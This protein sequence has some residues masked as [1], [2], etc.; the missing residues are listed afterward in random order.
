MCTGI[1]CIHCVSCWNYAWLVYE[2][3]FIL[4]NPLQ[5]SVRNWNKIVNNRIAR[6]NWVHWCDA[7]SLELKYRNRWCCTCFCCCC[8]NHIRAS[9]IYGSTTFLNDNGTNTAHHVFRI[10]VSGQTVTS[11][12]VK[13]LQGANYKILDVVAD[14]GNKTFALITKYPSSSQNCAILITNDWS[15]T[16][17]D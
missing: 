5:N 1:C 2:I 13:R 6:W 14:T 4:G 3:S 7:S 17:G 8:I 11:S 9:T 12:K 10:I 15:L 16:T